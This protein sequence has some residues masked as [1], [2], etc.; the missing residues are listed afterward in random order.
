D[1]PELLPLL[2]APLLEPPELPLDVPPPLLLPVLLPPLDPV[3]P[4]SGWYPE[5]GM[6][7]PADEQP[8][9]SA[10]MESATVALSD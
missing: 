8:A 1:P 2:A 9:A 4:G 6:S 7:G 10:R 5:P 3:A